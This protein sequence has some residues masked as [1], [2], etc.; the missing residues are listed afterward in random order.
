MKEVHIA[1]THKEGTIYVCQMETCNFETHSKRYLVEHT[2]ICKHRDSKSVSTTET[3]SAD[4]KRSIKEESEDVSGKS[5]KSLCN[6]PGCDFI[7]LGVKE[8]EMHDHFRIDHTDSEMTENSFIVINS[9]IAEAME[10]LQEM[11][12]IK[13]EN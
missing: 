2:G 9:A 12:E 13:K 10:I 4:I 3:V 1:S 11:Q 6:I 5:Q 8:T 7:S